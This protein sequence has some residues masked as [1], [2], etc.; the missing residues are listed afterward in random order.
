MTVIA[1]AP[2]FS[3]EGQ[4]CF[5]QAGLDN[6][7]KDFTVLPRFIHVGSS[8]IPL[9]PPDELAVAIHLAHAVQGDG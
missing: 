9:A 4:K 7:A 8:V 5:Q 1:L 2:R 3:L 6:I